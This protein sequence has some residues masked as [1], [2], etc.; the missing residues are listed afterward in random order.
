MKVTWLTAKPTG[1]RYKSR[2][3]SQKVRRPARPSAR[4]PDILARL[5]A[6]ARA[7]KRVL[8]LK[9]GDPLVFGR[10][11]EE[12]LALV[13]A[14]VKFR[15]VPGITAGTGGLAYAGIPL[16]HRNTNAAVT[17]V[18][19]H[20]ANGAVP[21]N[22]NWQALA[23]GGQVLVFYMALTH[24]SEICTRLISYGRRRDEPAALVVSAAT[25][26][27]RV[28]ETTIAE[29][30]AAATREALEPPA[31]FVVGDV[32]RLRAGLDWLGA[33]GGRSLVA[34]PLNLDDT[35]QAG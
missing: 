14:G 24:L 15:I 31:L 5:I 8:R 35:R 21:D 12:A 2:K 7:G 20:N 17:F 30:T 10:G 32:V 23:L 3:G 1:I 9:G 11:A 16:T 19:G 13:A 28:V 34:D 27:Q 25:E 33:L 18:T 29:A 4:Q 22:L 26:R 6:H